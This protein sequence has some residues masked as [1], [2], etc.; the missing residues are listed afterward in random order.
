MLYLCRNACIFVCEVV[1]ECL[2]DTNYLP[3]TYVSLCLS[4]QLAHCACTRRVQ[5]PPPPVKTAVLLLLTTLQPCS[6]SVRLANLVF[7]SGH[8]TRTHLTL[9]TIR[10]VGGGGRS[11]GRQIYMFWC[12]IY[13]YRLSYANIQHGRWI[14][15]PSHTRMLPMPAV[16]HPYK[17]G[18]EDQCQWSSSSRCVTWYCHCRQQHARWVSPA[19]CATL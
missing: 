18:L 13:V 9:S 15:Q 17:L 7:L 3:P 10:C 8:Q 2:S 6:W 12:G 19:A 5:A 11:V 1:S 4:A 14:K 16:C